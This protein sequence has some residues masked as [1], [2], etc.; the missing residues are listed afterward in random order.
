ESEAA[1]AA[2]DAGKPEAVPDRLVRGLTVLGGRREALERFDAY[3][4]AGA[5]LV[6]C[7][8]VPAREPFSSIL[9]TAMTAAPEP[10]VER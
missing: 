6:L 1:A 9:G 2:I 10:A 3:H 4:R 5:D 8:P 7:Y